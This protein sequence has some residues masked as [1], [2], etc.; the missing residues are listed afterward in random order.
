MAEEDD[1]LTVEQFKAQWVRPADA[2]TA[3]TPSLGREGAANALLGRLNTGHFQAAAETHRVRRG[4]DPEVRGGLIAMPP[5]LFRSDLIELDSP[6]WILGDITDRGTS[7]YS[8]S[9]EQIHYTGVRFDPDGVREMLPTNRV[10]VVEPL[11]GSASPHSTRR[12]VGGR[13]PKPWPSVMAHVAGLIHRGTLKPK[14]QAD[15]ERAM[16]EWFEDQGESIGEATV[17]EPSS[18]LWKAMLRP[19]TQEE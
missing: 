11:D 18:L 10:L 2:L 15:I 14:L 17:R 1:V 5:Y 9:G 16:M 6:F 8:Y 19:E 4:V 13:P 12:G 3:L 7:N